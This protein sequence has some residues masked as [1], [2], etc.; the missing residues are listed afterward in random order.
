VKVDEGILAQRGEA[1]NPLFYHRIEG[2][3]LIKGELANEA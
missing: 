2:Y 1:P 3:G